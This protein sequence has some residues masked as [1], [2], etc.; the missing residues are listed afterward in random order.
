MFPAALVIPVPAD[1]AQAY[2]SASPENLLLVVLRKALREFR[3]RPVGM[4]CRYVAVPQVSAYIVSQRAHV[5]LRSTCRPR[6]HMTTSAPR[7]PRHTP[8]TGHP[9]R[10]VGTA[11]GRAE[12]I[13]EPQWTPRN[14]R[15]VFV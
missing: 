10:N 11:G 1:T 6:T 12:V 2:S 8:H 5:V 14:V 4:L 15:G 7:L 9:D 3:L 13:V